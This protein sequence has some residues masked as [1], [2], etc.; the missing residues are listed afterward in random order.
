MQQEIMD[1]VR[2]L[3]TALNLSQTDFGRLLAKSLP[4]IQRWETLR[5][6]RGRALAQLFDLAKQHYGKPG[7]TFDKAGAI[8]HAALAEEMGGIP[9][10][11]V[12]SLDTVTWPELQPQTSEEQ[13]RVAALLAAMR[14]PAGEKAIEKIDRLL[15]PWL[16]K[17]WNI[18]LDVREAKK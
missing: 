12:F 4:T 16:S 2:S 9:I 5:P 17:T 1:S 3:R 8:F 13:R 18:E 11:R 14:D 15:K 6:P 10:P 7:D